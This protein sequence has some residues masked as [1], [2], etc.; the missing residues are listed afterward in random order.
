[1]RHGAAPSSVTLGARRVSVTRPRAR[2]TDGTQVQ[3]ESFAAFAG[4]DLLAG[5]VQRD[6][7]IL[8]LRGG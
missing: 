2:R 8:T 6:A 7:D 1:M 4:D 5:V 3:L